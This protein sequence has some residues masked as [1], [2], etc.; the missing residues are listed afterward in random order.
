MRY[1]TGWKVQNE[2]NWDKAKQ[3]VKNVVSEPRSMPI[4]EEINKL[5]VFFLDKYF[6]LKKSNIEITNNSLRNELDIYLKKKKSK[7]NLSSYRSLLECY[8]FYYDH[9]AK[10]PLPTTKS[11]L[12]EG[13][14]KS[15]KTSMK[16]IRQFNDEEYAINY[17]RITL[18]FYYDYL[19]FLRGKNYSNNYISKQIKNLK[20][21]MNFAWEHK[22]H[23]N[24][25]FKLKAFTKI[26]EQVNHIYLNQEEISK[27]N[28]LSLDGNIGLARDLFI[29]AANTGLRVSDFNRLTESNIKDYRGKKY[30]EIETRKTKSMVTIP[31][32]SM[33]K[34]I[35]EKY[36]GH[37]PGYMV[38]QKINLYLKTIGSR[39]GLK[40]KV[41]IK[42]TIGG[43][44][45]IK[46]YSKYDLIT[47]HTARRSFCTNAYKSGMPTLD[48]MAISGHKTERSFYNYIKIGDLERL[49][50]ISE[51]PFFN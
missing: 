19:E 41:K 21:I 38:E 39:A 34:D 25:E 49:E 48:I 33:V 7:K 18:S 44:T 51:H 17:D 29:L 2:K 47:C 6:E 9:F 40:E 50:K 12:S 37:P 36:G 42:K 14:V 3:R 16:L 24:L 11:S 30:I 8:E 1:S 43:K 22:Y 45:D 31:I 10:N 15:Y 32:N 27:I 4:N 26:P 5:E 23:N 35:L 28:A 13:T 20:T 46:E